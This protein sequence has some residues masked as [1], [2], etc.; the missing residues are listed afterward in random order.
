VETPILAKGG[1]ARAWFNEYAVIFCACAVVLLLAAV[2]LA[3][4]RIRGRAV[5]LPSVNL[6]DP[7]SLELMIRRCE[8][9][10]RIYDTGC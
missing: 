7:A 6:S 9:S 4:V 2:T 1:G 5:P 8:A 10:A 3:V